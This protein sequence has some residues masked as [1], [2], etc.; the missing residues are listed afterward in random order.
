MQNSLDTNTVTQKILVFIIALLALY[1]SA[2]I[3]TPED[4]AMYNTNPNPY[5]VVSLILSV[6]YGFGFSFLFSITAASMY[7]TLLHLQTDYKEVET[8]LTFHYLTNPLTI[9]FTSII[10]GENKTRYLNR[11]NSI[12]RNDQNTKDINTS[13]ITENDELKK[14]NKSLKKH[15]VNKLDTYQDALQSTKGFMDLDKD[16][17]ISFYFKTITRKIQANEAYYFEYQFDTEKFILVNSKTEGSP[18]LPNEL[19]EE[20]LNNPLIKRSLSKKKIS[21]IRDTDISNS[22]NNILISIPICFDNH[23][24]GIYLVSKIPFL[25]YTPMNFSLIEIFTTW[26][27]TA[28][29]NSKKFENTNSNLQFNNFLSIYTYSYFLKYLKA[30]NKYLNRYNINSKVLSVKIKS[31]NELESAKLFKVK[32]VLIQL[33]KD[34]TNEIDLI[35]ESESNTQ[36]LVLSQFREE[37]EFMAFKEDLLDNIFSTL[38]HSME[39][40]K[41]SIDLMVITNIDSERII[42]GLKQT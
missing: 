40:Y 24:L 11:L 31:D 8:L 38:N 39:T 28:L 5:L 3:I 1:G 34:L 13:L 30:T 10:F 18:R 36:L 9:I 32:K 25:E 42:E 7:M 37:D 29:I 16:S 35:A 19:N 23:I 4:L 14:E 17:L 6:V 2:Y 41:F 26:I 27:E 20:Y 12:Q 21:T 33:I 22:N 15:I